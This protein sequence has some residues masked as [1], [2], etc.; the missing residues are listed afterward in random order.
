MQHVKQ[1]SVQSG[2]K[3]Y[4]CNLLNFWYWYEKFYH[5]HIVLSLELTFLKI[6]IISV[7]ISNQCIDFQISTNVVA[8]HARMVPSVL[9]VSMATHVTANQDGLELSVKPVSV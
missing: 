5:I 8:F 9:M 1:L 6:Y 3:I 2:I 7:L 4:L